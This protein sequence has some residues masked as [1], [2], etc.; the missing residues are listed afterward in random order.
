MYFLVLPTLMSTCHL[1]PFLSTPMNL[2]RLLEVPLCRPLELF[3]CGLK[4]SLFLPDILRILSRFLSR[5]G[6]LFFLFL[7]LTGSMCLSCCFVSLFSTLSVAF[8]DR[9]ADSPFEASTFSEH[10]QQYSFHIS[11]K[12]SDISCCFG[13]KYVLVM[14]WKQKLLVNH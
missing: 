12:T 8:K 11:I 2:E 6:R 3:R 4:E 1:N 14:I 13:Y 10:P 9:W 7:F 5:L